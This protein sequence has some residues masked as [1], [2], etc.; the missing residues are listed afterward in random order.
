VG[1]ILADAQERASVAIEPQLTGAT[2][3]WS[4][5]RLDHHHHRDWQSQEAAVCANVDLESQ[6]NTEP[7]FFVAF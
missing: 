6:S 3:L 7:G 2:P 5:L 4:R 1:I